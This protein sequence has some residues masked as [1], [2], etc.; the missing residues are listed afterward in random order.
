MEPQQAKELLVKYAAGTCTP[1]ER[2][3]VESWYL[4]PAPDM[5]PVAPE[6][7][8]AA[9]AAVRRNLPGTPRPVRR[10]WPRIAAAASVIIALSAGGYFLLHKSAT[11]QQTARLQKNDIAPGHNQATLTLASGQQIILT[12]G[13]KGQLATQNHTV[14]SAAQNA[15]T[16][17]ANSKSDQLVYNTLSTARGEQS[18]YPLVL[19]DGTKVWLNAES[20]VT[21]PTAFNGK[22]RIVKVTGEAYFEVVHN[23]QQ[24][25]I[26]QTA[27][28]TIQDVGTHFDV[29]AYPDEQAATTL[30]EGSVKVNGLLIKPGEQ[31]DGHQIKEVNTAKVMAWKD[32]KFRFT[33]DNIQTVMRQLARWYAI[34]V[35]YAGTPGSEGFN[36]IMSRNQNISVILSGLERTNGVHFK[37]EGRRVTVI[38]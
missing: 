26:V 35:S 32:G 36:A 1:E 25:F 12:K 5:E 31:S 16:Y 33:N 6:E 24:P 27:T 17:N 8:E 14:I 37:I 22:S 30:I 3:W 23:A 13:L 7:I 15:I 4:Q 21:F 11:Q 29:V 38:E 20:S 28:Q 19:A 18:P 34:D 2:A 9:K 10:L